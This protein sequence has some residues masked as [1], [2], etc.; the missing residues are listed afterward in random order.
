MIT[1]WF[2]KKAV[3]VQKWFERDNELKTFSVDAI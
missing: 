1:N 2:E 3:S